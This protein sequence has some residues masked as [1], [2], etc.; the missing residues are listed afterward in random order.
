MYTYIYVFTYVSI[1][2][3]PTYT[4]THT[5]THK[6]TLCL[7]THAHTHIIHV[8]MYVFSYM[9]IYLYMVTLRSDAAGEM[10]CSRL[11][12]CSLSSWWGLQGLSLL[13]RRRSS[14]LVACGSNKIENKTKIYY[15]FQTASHTR[16]R[17]TFQTFGCRLWIFGAFSCSRAWEWELRAGTRE[18]ARKL[19]SSASCLPILLLL[20]CIWFMPVC[21][22]VYM[23][24]YTHICL[25]FLPVQTHTHTYAHRHTHATYFL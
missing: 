5:H 13:L 15:S 20:V 21:M 8:C 9:Y 18:V 11:S 4:H 19:T 24:V 12:A 7:H 6:V 1:G 25:C 2:T 10:A 3:E 23:C 17:S 22:Y 14:Y 16:I